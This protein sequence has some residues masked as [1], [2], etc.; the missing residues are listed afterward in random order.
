MEDINEIV[1]SL[2]TNK[3]LIAI[4]KTLGSVKVDTS[5]YLNADN[6]SHELVLDYDASGPSFVF[7]LLNKETQDDTAAN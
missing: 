5:A 4:L 3:V 7:S 2:N 6:E 1:A